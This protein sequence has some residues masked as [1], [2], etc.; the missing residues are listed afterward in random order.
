M[1]EFF[2][3]SYKSGL[4]NFCGS[5]VKVSYNP[6]GPD[7]KECFRLFEDGFYRGKEFIETRHPN[8]VFGVITGKKSWGLWKNE[9]TDGIVEGSFTKYE[10]LEEFHKMNIKIPEPLFED[11][12]NTLW[13]KRFLYE[14]KHKNEEHIFLKMYKSKNNRSDFL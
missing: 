13:K 3:K 11:F 4:L 6:D 5:Q 9:W 1:F 2:F 14:E 10:I 8:I 12:N 7:C